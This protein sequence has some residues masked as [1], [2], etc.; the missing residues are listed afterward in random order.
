[1]ME[2]GPYRLKDQD[3]LVYNNGSWNEFANL[4]FVD[5][6]VGTGFSSVDTNNYIHE[7]KEMADQF[8][9]F[10][11]KWFDLFPQYDRDDVSRTQYCENV[12][13]LRLSRSTSQASP[14]LD[15]TF[16]TSPGQFSIATRRTP[17]PHGT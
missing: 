7:L 12:S 1:M 16:L 11:E 14:M 10:L 6:P 17:K 4:L 2:I 15:N 13:M 5:N 8:V 3:H 9:I